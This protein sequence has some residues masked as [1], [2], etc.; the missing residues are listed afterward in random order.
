MNCFYCKLY[1]SITLAALFILFIR[2]LLDLQ[3]KLLRLLFLY[4]QKIRLDLRE[5]LGYALIE[6]GTCL[7][8]LCIRILIHH[9]ILSHHLLEVVFASDEVD[10]AVRRCIQQLLVVVLELVE[11]LEAVDAVDQDGGV[12][13]LEVEV[14]H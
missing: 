12:A 4:L 9:P 6:L 7:I 14:E 3:L 10:P 13:A 8:I 11:G 2:V 5:Q 1:K